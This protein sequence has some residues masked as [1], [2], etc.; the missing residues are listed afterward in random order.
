MVC[1]ACKKEIR[2]GA[3]LC[4]FCGARQVPEPPKIER[5]YCEKCKKEFEPEM[6]FCDECGRK[7]RGKYAKPVAEFGAV[8]IYRGDKAG[9][10]AIF[11]GGLCLFEER[12]E[13]KSTNTGERRLFVKMEEIESASKGGQK[14]LWSSLVLKMKDGAEFTVSGMSASADTVDR[15]MR[16][17]NRN[18]LAA[19]GENETK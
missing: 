14:L 4:S 8:S 5:M 16:F 15:M 12:I 17:I 7:L 11:S 19:S 9:G 1:V 2:D 13:I 3:A 18:I 10:T 6:I